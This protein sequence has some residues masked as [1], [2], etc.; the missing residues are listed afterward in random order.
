M[1]VVSKHRPEIYRRSHRHLQ[2]H[3]HRHRHPISVALGNLHLH[4]MVLI[5]GVRRTATEQKRYG[6]QEVP[7]LNGDLY[8][9]ERYR[10]GLWILEGTGTTFIRLQVLHSPV[11]NSWKVLPAVPVVR[12]WLHEGELD[13]PVL[14]RRDWLRLRRRE[15]CP[16]R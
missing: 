16:N 8:T 11:G 7:P 3:R 1:T 5:C 14:R 15:P 2:R 4:T 10:K 13:G 12:V 9:T 6:S